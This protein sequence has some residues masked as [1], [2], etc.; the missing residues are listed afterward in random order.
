L[1]H[2]EEEAL[3]FLGIYSTQ[4]AKNVTASLDLVR[5]VTYKLWYNSPWHS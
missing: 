1:C 2:F 4:N 3:P 5:W